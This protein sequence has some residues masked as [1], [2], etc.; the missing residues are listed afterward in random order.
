MQAL[1]CVSYFSIIG[2]LS[3]YVVI[4]NLLSDKY[5]KYYLLSYLD[6]YSMDYLLFYINNFLVIF[7][8]HLL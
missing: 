7:A 8:Q 4:F 6:K 2:F 1:N 5:F 3:R